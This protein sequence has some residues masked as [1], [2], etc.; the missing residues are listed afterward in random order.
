MSHSS[1]QIAELATESPGTI[2]NAPTPRILGSALWRPMQVP[3]W[4]TPEN[5][6]VIVAA[7]GM[8]LTDSVGRSYI[9]MTAGL[10]YTN[11][12]HGRREIHD[13]IVAQMGRLTTFPIF[14]ELSHD[15]VYELSDRLIEATAPE[16]MQGVFFGGGGSDSVETAIKLAR[17]YWKIVGRPSKTRL[18]SFDDTYHGVNFGALSVTSLGSMQT[19][20]EP[21][22]PGSV[23]MPAPTRLT[24]PHQGDEASFARVVAARIE[25]TIRAIGADSI[26][27]IIAEPVQAAGGVIIPPRTLWGELRRLCDAHDI[28][29]IADEVLTGFGRTG[30][31]FGVRHWDV[32]P[33]MMCLSKG[34]TSGYVPMGATLIGERIA[35]DW[36]AAGAA[37]LV[38][39]GYTYSG[40]PLAC[41]AALANLDMLAR[42]GLVD[43]ARTLGLYLLDRLQT[44]ATHPRVRQV[45]GLGLMAAIDF[46]TA[47]DAEGRPGNVQR[48][49]DRVWAYLAAR[50]VLVRRATGRLMITPP[51]IV[52]HE[53]VDNLVAALAE[54]L[55]ANA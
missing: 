20:Y 48:L 25:E 23:T 7:E 16:R 44:L 15:L 53:D 8:R 40:H 27:A 45:R 11:V 37:G 50:G 33:D 6:L 9:D 42:E 5:T 30:E 12:G 29:L 36:H 43:R 34:L 24:W 13:A 3:G 28:L 55:S 46:Q 19:P 52:T 17:Q 51:L 31:M 54:G 47:P 4:S 32:V 2:A 39:H 14:S 35:R 26:A 21:M 1:D 10:S 49:T 38:H 22:L 18:L 41:A